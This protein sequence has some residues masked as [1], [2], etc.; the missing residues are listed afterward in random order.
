MGNCRL[1]NLSEQN[2]NRIAELAMP[3]GGLIEL[4]RT[5]PTNKAK[6][7]PTGRNVLAEMAF[8]LS[9][10][11]LYKKYMPLFYGRQSFK[12]EMEGDL[13]LPKRFFD[14]IG[15]EN[16]KAITNIS[17]LVVGGPYKGLGQVN[18]NLAA[19]INDTAKTMC[20]YQCTGKRLEVHHFSMPYDEEICFED[21]TNMKW[22]W[23]M[24]FAAMTRE[25]AL[26]GTFARRNFAGERLGFW[27]MIM[28]GELYIKGHIEAVLRNANWKFREDWQGDRYSDFGCQPT[29]GSDS[30]AA[31]EMW[32]QVADTL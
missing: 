15:P 7:Q 30:N 6:A 8:P 13:R 22:S 3:D 5:S 31:Y 19:A 21:V 2:L 16:T 9:C 10:K 12:F 29:Q 20:Q 18:L 14:Q 23:D 26:G 32:R 24:V 4:Y 27:K 1:F 17:I 25:T 28:R 11:K